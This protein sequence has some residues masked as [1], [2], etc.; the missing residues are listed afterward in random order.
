MAEVGVIKSLAKKR[1]AELRFKSQRRKSALVVKECNDI[2]QIKKRP[3]LSSE[4]S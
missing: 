4:G 2:P 3:R 1:T